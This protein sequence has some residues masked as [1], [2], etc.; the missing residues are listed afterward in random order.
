[1]KKI[2]RLH[3]ACTPCEKKAAR[4]A[5]RQEDLTLSEWLRWVVRKETRRVGVW[6]VEDRDVREAA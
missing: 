5:A 6:S 2:E 4:A 1:M 3:V